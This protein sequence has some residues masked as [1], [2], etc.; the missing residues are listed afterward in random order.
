MNYQQKEKY[1]HYNYIDKPLPVFIRKAVETD[2]EEEE[3]DRVQ[4]S[5]KNM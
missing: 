4:N 2:S 5:I 3:L 1:N